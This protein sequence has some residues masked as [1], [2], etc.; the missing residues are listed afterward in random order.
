MAHTP[1]GTPT[2]GAGGP[3]TS[4]DRRILHHR[5]Q[6]ATP[7]APQNV[8]ARS[9]PGMPRNAGLVASMSGHG[10]GRMTALRHRLFDLARTTP[11]SRLSGHWR[12]GCE[13]LH[14]RVTDSGDAP[15]ADLTGEP[16]RYI[17][18]ACSLRWLTGTRVVSGVHVE[19]AAVSKC[20][21]VGEAVEL[22]EG[23]GDDLVVGHGCAALLGCRCSAAAPRAAATAARR[24]W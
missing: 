6:S 14:V 11:H 4:P 1:K 12:I 16:C 13:P 5:S 10:Q 9:P 7:N 18:T 22:L 23:V 2:T 8:R 15:Q 19:G 21:M 3:T 24:C 17:C 20:S